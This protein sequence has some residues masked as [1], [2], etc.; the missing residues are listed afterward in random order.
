MIL[1]AGTDYDG[2]VPSLEFDFN[3]DLAN[4]FGCTIVV[5]VKGFGRSPDE[6]LH[7]VHMAHESMVDRRGDL[8]ATIVNGVDRDFVDQVQ[9]RARAVLPITETLYVLPQSD[10]LA[11]PTIGEISQ[12]LGGECLCGEDEALNQM[13]T[14]YKVAAMEIPDFLNYIEDGC[15]IITPGDRAISSWRVSPRM[16]RRL[17]RTWPGSCSPVVCSRRRTSSVCS[18]ACG[19][20]RSRS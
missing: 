14:N 15:L 8:L 2:L 11:N 17:T 10:S 18:R 19:A 13:V 1:C 6:A 12:M 7:A 16:Y 5:V 4:N 3:A 9:R 20:T